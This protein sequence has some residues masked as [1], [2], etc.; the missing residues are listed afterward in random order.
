[1]SDLPARFSAVL[2]SEVAGLRLD[3]A[4]VRLRPDIT[5]STWQ[6]WMEDGR[7]LLNGAPARKRDRVAGGETV[8][9]EIP[10]P[11]TSEHAAEAIP[12]VVVYED[13]AI[14]VLDKP[15]GLVVHPGAGNAE[16]TLLNALLHHAPALAA[17]PRAGI[18]HRLDKDTSG[19]MVVAKTEAARQRLIAQLDTRSMSREYLAVVNG[20]L[21][22]GT[23]VEAAI[24]RHHVDRKRMAVTARGKPAVSHVR[25]LKKFRGHTLVQ[26]K[27]ESGRTHQIRVHLA[28]IKYPVVGD[29]V[30]GGRAKLPK[31]ARPALVTALQGFRRQALHAARLT[32]DHPETGERMQWEAPLPEDMRLLIAELEKDAKG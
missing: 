8:S 17:L 20:V 1:M 11:K 2:P 14:V 25:I 24:G 31:G 23:T 3:Q 22:A 10:P 19:L 7:V 4:L 27:L 29:P 13:E 12:L 16:G 21:I 9:V 15:P 5:R 6:L 26:V 28:H 32:L 30:Y 18:V